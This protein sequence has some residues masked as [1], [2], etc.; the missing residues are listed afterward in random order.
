M[1]TRV[2]PGLSILRVLGDELERAA[3]RRGVSSAEDKRLK[4]MR[5]VEAKVNRLAANPRSL[6]DLPDP[7]S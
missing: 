6:Q 3:R 5:R 4:R 2:V 7:S 1:A